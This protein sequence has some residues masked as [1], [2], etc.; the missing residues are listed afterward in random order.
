MA[1]NSTKERELFEEL[2]HSRVV[3]L[4]IAAAVSKSGSVPSTYPW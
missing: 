4:N 2:P 1:W 3:L